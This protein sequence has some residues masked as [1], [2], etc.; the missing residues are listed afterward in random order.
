MTPLENRLHYPLGDQLPAPGETLEVSPGVFWLRMGL[1]FALDHINL[2]L[3]RDVRDGVVGWTAVDCGIDNPQ[4]RQHWQAVLDQHL[5]GAP[6][7][8]VIVT[9]MHP[10]HLGLGHWLCERWQAQLW[11]SFTDYQA[12]VL[13]TLHRDSFGGDAAAAFFQRHGLHD[14]ASLAQVRGR[15]TYYAG[16]VPKIPTQFH[17]LQ[18][19]QTVVING[20]DWRCISG[21]GHAPEHIALFQADA[22]VLI[23]GDMVLPRIST[24]VSVYD[25]EPEADN[26][27][28]F[29]VSIDKFKPLPE[30]T[31][32]LPSHGKPFVGLH[33]RIAQL[34]AHHQDR[35][36]EVFEACTQRACSAHDVL[37]VLFKR[38]L[39]LHQTTFAMGEAVAHLHCLWHA[40]QLRRNADAQGV[41]R[42]T[43][44]AESRL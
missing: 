27:R 31:L 37:P 3:L 10:D 32:T 5:Q 9:H 30:N 40:G 11:I 25:A 17:R 29:L 20:Q 4:T 23:S 14:E 41:W 22:G 36:D 39:D 42:F 35:L 7:W 1:P 19:G 28:L 34:H 21:F 15:S 13:A 44:V 6:L 18:D 24:N 16:M 8:R 43:S 2:W 33:E 12:A 26:L 38:P